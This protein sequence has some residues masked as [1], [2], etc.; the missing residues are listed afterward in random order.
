VKQLFRP[1][2]KRSIELSRFDRLMRS[3]LIGLVLLTLG[4]CG[5]IALMSMPVFDPGT[6]RG[7]WFGTVIMCLWGWALFVWA[8]G[9][10]PLGRSR[11]QSEQHQPAEPTHW[12][13][14]IR[15][16]KVTVRL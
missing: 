16:V 9:V 1:K 2:A 10:I 11:S 4:L 12:V 14:P 7:G 13:R 3:Y 6:F 15:R 5:L 8:I